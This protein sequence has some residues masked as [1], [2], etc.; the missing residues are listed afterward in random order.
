L[1]PEAPRAVV[2]EGAFLQGRDV[3]ALG[4]Q[5]AIE[6][7]SGYLA[8]AQVLYQQAKRRWPGRALKAK[9]EIEQ[10]DNQKAASQRENG[11]QSM[12]GPGRR[13]PRDRQG[14]RYEGQCCQPARPERN[15]SR[16]PQ[17]VGK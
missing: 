16:R 10:A 15:Q 2:I 13:R 14:Q 7:H 5:Q 12:S 1:P 4:P 6:S 17:P 3:D 11:A 8:S 9:P